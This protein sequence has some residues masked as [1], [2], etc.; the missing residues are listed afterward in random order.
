M[1]TAF[2]LLPAVS[3]RGNILATILERILGER[4]EGV[5]LVNLKET[6]Q[7]LQLPHPECQGPDRLFNFSYIATV[8]IQT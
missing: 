4:V 5:G 7:V 8:W 6:L 1:Y 3:G 2:C